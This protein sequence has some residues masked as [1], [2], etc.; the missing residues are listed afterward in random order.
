[1]TERGLTH[2][3]GATACPFVAFEDD[4][5]ERSDRPDH[6]HR[7]YADVHPAPRAIAHQEAYCLSSAFAVCPTF[8][9]W[10]QREAARARAAGAAQAARDADD[11]RRRDTGPGTGLPDAGA[12]G[13]AARE[14]AEEREA[15]ARSESPARPEQPA[16]SEPAVQPAAEWL[17]NRPIREEEPPALPPRRNPPRDW[18]APP[19]WAGGTGPGGPAGPGA[20]GAA[21]LSGAARASGSR[22]GS[23]ERGEPGRPSST[24]SGTPGTPSFLAEREARGLAGSA[25]DRLAAGESFVPRPPEGPQQGAPRADPWTPSRSTE[26]AQPADEELARLVRG[27]DR[28][29]AEDRDDDTSRHRVAGAG[30]AGAMPGS[31][32][33]AEHPRAPRRSPPVNGRHEADDAPSWEQPRR[34]EAYPTIKARPSVPGLPRLGIMA[35]A[36]GIAAL[37]LFLLPAI[38][39]WFGDNDPGGGTGTVATPSPSLAIESASPPPGTAAAPTPQIYVIKSGDT[40]SK[41][42]TRFNVTLDDLLEANKDN[43]EDADKISIGDQIIIPAPVPDGLEDAGEPS[44]AP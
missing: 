20:A 11:A 43:I 25:A 8:Q 28:D 44:A 12:A 1:M 4:R 26:R 9:E 18:A 42:A 7:C 14:V 24:D 5:D 27:R 3:D 41:I 13:S 23:P 22:G 21:G 16:H 32:I 40:L 17:G 35:A 39:G 19:P 15:A 33:E 37:A 29:Q 38:L 2:S 34:F 6:R 31:G 10:A 36:V 30:A